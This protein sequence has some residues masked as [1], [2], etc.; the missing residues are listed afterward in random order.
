M[1]SRF[2]NEKVFPSINKP[3][4]GERHGK[5]IHTSLSDKMFTD[6]FSSA[7][8]LIDTLFPLKK[9]LKLMGGG[10][11]AQ[12]ANGVFET[13]QESGCLL[14]QD[15]IKRSDNMVLLM[16]NCLIINNFYPK[17]STSKLLNKL[18]AIC[19]QQIDLIYFTNYRI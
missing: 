14:K 16:N 4:L 2:K 9:Y 10:N 3:G 5:Q 13:L 1:G 15:N 19:S 18:F 6:N 8:E 17:F 12:K 7:E 11:Q